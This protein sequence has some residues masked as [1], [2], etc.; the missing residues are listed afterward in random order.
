VE[1]G[2]SEPLRTKDGVRPSASSP[3]RPDRDGQERSGVP[4]PPLL[5]G[6]VQ[7]GRASPA[8]ARAA[9]RESTKGGPI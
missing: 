2:H 9:G 5:D 7:R 8:G 4:P 1:R 3:K 6:P